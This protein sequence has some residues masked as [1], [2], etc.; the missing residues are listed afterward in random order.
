MTTL[1]QARRAFVVQ[2]TPIVPTLHQL[3]TAMEHA[4]WQRVFQNKLEEKA[5]ATIEEVK[6]NVPAEPLCPFLN[7]PVPVNKLYAHK[8][9]GTLVR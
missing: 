1:Y 8:Y 6:R 5:H 9:K 7:V 3:L 4:I 2:F